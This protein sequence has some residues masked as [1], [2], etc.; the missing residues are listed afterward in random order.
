MIRKPIALVCSL[1]LSALAAAQEKPPASPAP[2]ASPSAQTPSFPAQVEL[3]NVDV[4]VTDKK[5][6][7][8]PGLT[9]EDFILMEDGKAQSI[10]SFEAV[11]APAAASAVP[12]AKPRVSRN[13]TPEVRA[14]TGRTFLVVFDDIHLSPHQAHRAKSAVAEFLRSG[15]REGDRVSLV[16]TGGGAWWS[17]RMEAGREELVA[18]LKRLDGRRIPDTSPDRMSDY[19]AMRIH[20]FHDTQVEERV[21]RRFETYGVSQRASQANQESSIAGTGDPFVR[22]RATEIYFQSVARN[23]ITLQVLQRVLL[24]LATTKGRKSL[25]LVSEGF[26]YDPNLDEFKQ[27]VQASRRANV[28]IYFLD[29]RG[30]EGTSTYFTAEFG[31]A[32]DTRDIG[33]AFAETLEASEG[34]ESLA[35]DSGGFSVKNTNDLANG[36]KRIADESRN[37]YLLGYHPTNAAADGRFRKIEVKLARKG[38]KVRARKGYYASLPGGKSTVDNKK[39]AGGDPDIQAALDSPYEEAAIPLRMTS[40]VYDETLLGKARVVVAAEVDMHD[41]AFEEKDGRFVGTLEA[42]MIVAHRETG[43]Y[44]RP[45]DQKV[46]MKVLPATREKLLAGGYPIS[47][48]FDLAPGGYQAKVVVRDKNRGAIGTVIHEFEVPELGALRVSTPLITDTLQQD[49]PAGG[50]ATPAPPTAARPALVVRREFPTQGMLYCQY[51]VYGAQTDK[52]S[53]MPKVSAGYQIRRRS[54][55][56]VVT[57]VPPSVITPTSIGKLSRMVGTGLPG[58]TP[59][60]YELVLSV[61]DELSGKSVEVREPFTLVEGQKPAADASGGA[62]GTA[63]RR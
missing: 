29:T 52:K 61:T 5:N 9:Q 47:H 6:T 2:E 48:E 56:T 41:F 60:E 24:S 33:A 20:V 42:L 32:L 44:F 15:V 27:V 3:V 10:A 36:V 14:G 45:P 11:T 25:V 30:L 34:S 17:T 54:D 26:I 21:A 22:G 55:G 7:S 43:E 38:F 12:P 37:Y 63:T 4:V 40:Y 51:E 50:A 28:A 1:A 53:G 16:A 31:P 57:T 23:R 35:A 49:R 8:V 18:M 62:A 58:A 46:E 13:T 39:V 59:G 19:E